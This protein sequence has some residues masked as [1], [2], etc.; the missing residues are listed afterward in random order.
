M[1]A[2]LKRRTRRQTSWARAQVREATLVV[3]VGVDEGWKGDRFG[4]VRSSPASAASTRRG[5]AC[6]RQ[7]GEGA[8]RTAFFEFVYNSHTCGSKV[9]GDRWSLGHVPRPRTP[10]LPIWLVRK[11]C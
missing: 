9:K 11:L 6:R 10:P 3:L 8:R 4:W 2:S 5:G 1:A 7:G